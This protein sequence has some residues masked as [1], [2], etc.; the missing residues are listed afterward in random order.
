MDEQCR[1]ALE[2]KDKRCFTADGIAREV[3]NLVRRSAAAESEE[4]VHVGGAHDLPHRI[5]S[6]LKLTRGKGAQTSSLA[7][8]SVASRETGIGWRRLCAA[9]QARS[10]CAASFFTCSGPAGLWMSSLIVTWSK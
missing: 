8:F 3:L 6:A 4:H 9:W 1:F 2:G 7:P 5:P 10:A